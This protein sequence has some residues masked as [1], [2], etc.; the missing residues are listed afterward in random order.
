MFRANSEKPFE[1]PHQNSNIVTHGISPGEADLAMIMIHGRGASAQSII[2]LSNEFD[3]G[4]IHY[5]APQANQFTWYPYSFLQPTE[6][7]EPG[8]SSGLQLIF[9]IISDLENEGIPKEKI[10]LLGFSQGACLSTEFVA[11]HPA[12]YGGLIALSGGLIGKSVEK[13]KYK[14]DLAGTPYFVGCSDVDPHIP[15]ERVDES[16]EVLKKLGAHITKK[17]Y[18]GMGHTVNQDEIEQ[19]KKILKS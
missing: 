14:G 10:V 12:K 5:R 11:R 1:G 13:E 7:N 15:V 3:T 18:P 2:T 9:D 4:K 17:I 19:I 6:Q 8:L 16:V